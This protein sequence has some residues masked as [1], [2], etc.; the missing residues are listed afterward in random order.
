M[1][2]APQAT[3]IMVLL[4]LCAIRTRLLLLVI[5]LY[6]LFVQ[7]FALRLTWAHFCVYMHQ[8]SKSCP[9]PLFG[10]LLRCSAHGCSFAGLRYLFQFL[11][12]WS[13]VNGLR[14][15]YSIQ[16]HHHPLH[17]RTSHLR[18]ITVD[19]SFGVVVE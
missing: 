11:F 15:Q 14:R 19:Y 12:R 18:H 4:V 7:L 10:R 6:D 5:L 9:P 2:C 8:H 3:P 16:D 1:W 13:L 17:V